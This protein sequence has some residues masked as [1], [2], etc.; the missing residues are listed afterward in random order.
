MPVPQLGPPGH[1]L[2]MLAPHATVAGLVVGQRAVHTH[3]PPVQVE[4][5]GQSV[6][7]PGQVAPAQR[8]AMGA[9]Q[10]TVAAV[11]HDGAHTHAPPAQVW[12]AGQRV[13]VPGH[14]RPGHTLGIGAPHVTAPAAGHAGTHS[15]A[16]LALQR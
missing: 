8:L 10:V 5:A 6:P 14:V 11:G 2:G 4:P 7:V 9:P 3:A 1:T 15:H 13:P 12:P 16:L